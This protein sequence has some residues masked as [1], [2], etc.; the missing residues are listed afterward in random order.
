MSI[1][2]CPLYV[3]SNL[4]LSLSLSSLSLSLYVVGIDVGRTNTDAALLQHEEESA[5]S[6]V[7]VASTVLSSDS[8]CVRLVGGRFTPLPPP[9]LPSREES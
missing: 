1:G 5:L 8:D 9:S 2:H 6:N 4:S 7:A 3:N